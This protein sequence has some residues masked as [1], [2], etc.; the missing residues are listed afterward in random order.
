MA[1]KKQAPAPVAVHTP[2]A[3]PSRLAGLDGLR[4]LAVGTVILF[5]FVPGALPGGFL[6]VDIFFVISG[7]LITTLLLRE[8]ATTGAIRL[9][10]FWVRRARRLLPAL[11]VLVLVATASALAIGGD[12]LVGIGRQVLGAA[13]FSY[14]WLAIATN[15]SYFDSTT[16][17]LFRNL[18]SLAVEEQFYLAWP[19]VILALLALTKRRGWMLLAV[20]ALAAGS[21]ATMLLLGQGGVSATRLY[22]GTDTHLFGLA[23]GASLAVVFG[24]ATAWTRALRISLPALGL[25]AVAGLVSLALLMPEDSAL[26]FQGGLLLVAVLTALAIAGAVAPGSPLGRVLDLPPLRWVGERSYGLYLWH[27]PVLVLATAA[28]PAWPELALGGLALGVTVLAATLS[29]R[30][31]EQPIR[32]RGFRAALWL[33]VA[34]LG[35]GPARRATAAL[36]VIA[37]ASLAVAS[38]IAVATAPASGIAQQRIEAGMDSVTALPAPAPTASAASAPAPLPGGDQIVAIGDSVMLAAADEVIAAFPGISIDAAVS[39]RMSSAPEMIRA[40]QA[41]GQMRPILLLGLGTNGPVSEETLQ[42]IS[43]L[44]GPSTSIVLVNAQ[45]PRGWIPG[46]NDEL[47]SFAQRYRN[48]ELANWY[49]AIQPRLDVLATDQIHAGGPIG[50]GIYAGAI[51]DAMQRLAELPPLLNSNDYGLTARP[52]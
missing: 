42:E 38:G 21:F 2:P 30:Y 23:I 10:S 9:R 27:W 8:H 46:V 40:L 20:A 7:F 39:R 33:W 34:R 12:V 35:A 43:E 17:E 45:A 11:I 29:Y 6:G 52:V 32:R 26:V 41:S 51:R 37:V 19:F 28:L 14:N 15:A 16:P 44:V 50:G 36:G 48:V 4:A 1:T 25:L 13:T 18:W 3:H 5:H 31:L 49:D 24:R 22:Y 47:A